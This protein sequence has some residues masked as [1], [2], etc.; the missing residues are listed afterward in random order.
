MTQIVEADAGQARIGQE[1]FQLSVGAVWADGSFWAKRI[2]EDPGGEGLFLPRPQQFR[3][4]GR[5]DDLSRS[6]IG[7]SVSSHQPAAF[8]SVKGAADFEGVAAL[9][10]V[11]PHESADFAPAQASGEFGVEEVVPE[12]IFL[13]DCHTDYGIVDFSRPPRM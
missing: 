3:C 12:W 7:F 5:Q 2:V 8:F 10:E 6:S 11:R 9:I 13:N 4:A 1:F